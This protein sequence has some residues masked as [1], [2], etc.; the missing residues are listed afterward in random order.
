M[1]PMEAVKDAEKRI[2]GFIRETYLEPSPCLSD[3]AG[4]DIHLKLE[5]LQHTGSF[6]LRGA[7]NKILKIGELAATTRVIAASSGNH[8]AAVA[9]AL[10]QIGGSGLVFVPEGASELKVATIRRF[11]AEVRFHGRDTTE[12]EAEA[13]AFAER[14]GGL[15]VSPYNDAD[16]VAGQGTIGIEIIRQLPNVRS[17]L[18]SVG[19]GGLIAGI[20]T[21]IKAVAPH[22]EIIGCSPENSRAMA[23]SVVAGRVIDVEHKPTLSDGTAGGLEPDTM[24]FEPCRRL[25]DHWIDVSEA[26]IAHAMK[27]FLDHHRM[28]AEGAAGVAIAAACKADRQRIPGPA[29]V[30][31]C[32]GNA[33]TSILKGIL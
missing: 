23:A 28:V 26:D 20:A 13:R 7:L 29:V 5:N 8:G 17:I 19:G 25:V 4:T 22:V 16:V 33:G 18:V 3:I 2:R 27:L 9:Y 10:K 6:K 12:T 14:S 32:G 1:I 24:T 15:Y 30:I 31:I 21:Y 11:G